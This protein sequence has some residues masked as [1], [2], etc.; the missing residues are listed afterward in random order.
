MALRTTRTNAVLEVSSTTYEEIATKLREAG[1][2]HAFDRDGHIDMH[3]IALA[4]EK[5]EVVDGY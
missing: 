4:K 3:G 2:D 5:V 1:Y